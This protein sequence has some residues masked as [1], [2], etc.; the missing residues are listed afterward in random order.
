MAA[1]TKRGNSREMRCAVFVVGLAIA[2][3]E[4]S[5][6]PGGSSTEPADEVE[7]L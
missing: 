6:E 4:V 5:E 2:A 1:A 7:R 3:P